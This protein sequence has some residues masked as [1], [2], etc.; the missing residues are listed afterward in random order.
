MSTEGTGSHGAGI[1]ALLPAEIAK[2]AE[3]IGAQKI[4]VENH[5]TSHA[6][7]TFHTT[8]VTGASCRVPPRRSMPPE[9]A[10]VVVDGRL[11]FDRIDQC[12]VDVRRDLA[13][14]AIDQ[15]ETI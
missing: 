1:D 10:F 2:K 15:T 9:T 12:S 5:T 13:N 8:R 7:E 11:P 6:P 14:S 4:R 3:Q